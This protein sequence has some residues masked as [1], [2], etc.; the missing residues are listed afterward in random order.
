MGRARTQALCSF[1]AQ[2]TLTMSFPLASATPVTTKSGLSLRTI[3]PMIAI[4]TSDT[5]SIIVAIA[6]GAVALATLYLGLKTRGMAGATKLV[7]E[8]TETEAQAVV[9][10]S[11]KVADQA[12][13]SEEQSRISAEA[14]QAFIRPWITAMVQ[15][16][17]P[18]KDPYLDRATI[19]LLRARED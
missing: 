10:Q 8:A 18:L 17:T 13:A 4:T 5:V 19:Y 11:R 7:A 12:A 15:G 14:L 2:G 9:E 6:S 1:V 3:P 16:E